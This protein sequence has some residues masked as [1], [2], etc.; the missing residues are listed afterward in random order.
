MKKRI[1]LITLAAL[2]AVSPVCFATP[3]NDKVAHFGIGYIINDQLQRNTKATFAERLLVVTTIGALK[4]GT[5]SRFDW[6]DLG[7]TVAGGLAREI[8]LEWKF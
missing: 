4:E 8:K 7:A 1:L 5:D 6:R 3:G 2:L